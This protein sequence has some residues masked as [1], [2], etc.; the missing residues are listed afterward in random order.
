MVA[1]VAGVA[2]SWS[3][4]NE[5]SLRIMWMRGDSLNAI[6]RDLGIGR[7]AVAGKARRMKLP[8]REAPSQLIDWNGRGTSLPVTYIRQLR[9]SGKSYR[10]IAN[11]VGCDPSA[12]R[13][14]CL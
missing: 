3:L 7:G 9:T 10:A 12:A 8:E 11:L 1:C 2:M 13:R 4:I 14:V 5:V 6:A